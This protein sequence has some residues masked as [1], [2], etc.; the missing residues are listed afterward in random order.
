MTIARWSGQGE[1]TF[2]EPFILN[3]NQDFNIEEPFYIRLDSNYSAKKNEQTYFKFS[4]NPSTKY[5]LAIVIQDVGTPIFYHSKNALYYTALLTNIVDYTDGAFIININNGVSYILKQQIFSL[6]EIEISTDDFPKF[7]IA[8]LEPSEKRKG[9]F[10][11]DLELQEGQTDEMFIVPPTYFAIE[12]QVEL[13]NA[14]SSTFVI[15]PEVI[16]VNEDYT[17]FEDDDNYDENG[18]F[19]AN[20]F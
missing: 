17:F 2:V 1:G 12:D 13:Q 3:V 5:L 6:N 4:N 19:I 9:D 18:N 15:T 16:E 8:D 20:Q 10:W 14:D 7:L 11:F